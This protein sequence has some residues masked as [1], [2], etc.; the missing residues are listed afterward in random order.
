MRFERNPDPVERVFAIVMYVGFVVVLVLKS[1]GPDEILGIT[2]I[3]LITLL[4]IGVFGIA[5]VFQ[6]VN[7]FRKR[8]K[9]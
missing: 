1:C 8:D 4:I 3:G 5:L 9:W 2:R 7:W 6:V